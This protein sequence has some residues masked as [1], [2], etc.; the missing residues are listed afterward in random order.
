VHTASE[1]FTPAPGGDA[2]YALFPKDRRTAVSDG[3][4]I[5]W[6]LLPAADGAPPRL[7]IVAANGWSCSDAYWAYIA[8]ALAAAGHP[9]LLVD[10]RGHG[11]SGLPRHPG[12]GA[13]KLRP[14]DV[15]ISRIATD[16]VEVAD[17]AGFDRFLLIGHSMGVQTSL[18]AHRLAPDRVAGLVL[19]AGSYENPLRTFMGMPL[20][21]AVF[22]FAKFAVA[23]TPPELTWLAMQP[24]RLTAFGAWAARRARATGP[25]AKAADMAPYL[26]HI[27]AADTAVM[28][29]AVDAMRRHSAADHLRHIQAPT[30]ILAA[31]RDTFTPPACS[32]HMFQRI[33]TAEIQW[34]DDAGHTLP[35]EEPDAIVAHVDEWYERRVAPHLTAS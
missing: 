10:A 22:P 11:A 29:R 14:E 23:A 35:I 9:V 17:D 15:T 27:A 1:P 24:A 25:K 5:A 20:L 13:R 19:V 31:G 30:L 34:F 4:P 18:E 7:P 2:G 12:R 33:P 3:T 32:Q 16:L 28:I 26:R 21:D 8:P 6:T